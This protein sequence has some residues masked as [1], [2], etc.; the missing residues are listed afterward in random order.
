MRIKV[1]Q[2]GTTQHVTVGVQGPAGPNFINLAEDVDVT[3]LTN[4]SL[5]IYKSDTQKW[6]SS[7]LLQNQTV[8]A[9]EY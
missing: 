9:G 5:L 3:N 7:T 1:N 2:Q 8:E 4:G 6:T